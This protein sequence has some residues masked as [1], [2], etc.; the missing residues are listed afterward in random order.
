MS[1][2]EQAAGLCRRLRVTC[3][4]Y[5]RAIRRSRSGWRFQKRLPLTESF[6]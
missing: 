5:P 1:V 6:C 2:E 3:N 4:G